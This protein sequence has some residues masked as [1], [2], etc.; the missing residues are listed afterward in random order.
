MADIQI[1]EP[2]KGKKSSTKN[3]IRVDMTPMVDLGFLLITFF[4]FTANFSKPNVINFANAPKNIH[5]VKTDI[6]VKN[7]IT[8]ILG[9]EGRVFYYQEERQNLNDNSI[10]EISFDKAQV[11]K[12]IEAAKSNAVNKSIFTVIIKPADDTNYKTVVDMLD[13]LAITKSDRYGISELNDREKE[14][15]QK[16]V[17]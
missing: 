1:K 5:D 11:A 8:F 15:Y 12:T 17:L 9:K 2:V 14:L 16:K 6:N 7:S 10:K 13:E 3:A 4:M